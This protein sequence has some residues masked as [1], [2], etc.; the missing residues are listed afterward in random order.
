[1]AQKKVSI[2]KAAGNNKRGPKSKKVE[3]EKPE[4]KVE[5]NEEDSDAEEEQNGVNSDDNSDAEVC[6][7]LKI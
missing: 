6:I 5:A 7:K 1:M 3:E 4:V 2:K